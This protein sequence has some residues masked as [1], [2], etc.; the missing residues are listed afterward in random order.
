MCG[1]GDCRGR[2]CRG[3]GKG[4]DR[5]WVGCG[6]RVGGSSGDRGRI[7][8]GVFGCGGLVLMW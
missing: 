6:S 3:L 8:C 2:D 7:G 1:T 4:N 5:S